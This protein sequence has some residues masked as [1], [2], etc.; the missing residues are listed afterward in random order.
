MY[1]TQT[2]NDSMSFLNSSSYILAMTVGDT[3]SYEAKHI[4]WLTIPI[5]KITGNWFNTLLWSYLP[6]SF[7]NFVINVS[8]HHGVDDSD[9][10]QPG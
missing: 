9:S 10:K 4:F 2:F 6:T 1:V 7:D 8:D 3:F 5:Q